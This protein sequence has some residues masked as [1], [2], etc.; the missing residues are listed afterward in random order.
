MPDDDSKLPGDK[1]LIRATIKTFATCDYCSSPSDLAIGCFEVN[2]LGRVSLDPPCFIC[3]KCFDGK[4]Y[5]V[6]DEED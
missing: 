5:W 3:Q 6:D 2:L 1:V 4:V